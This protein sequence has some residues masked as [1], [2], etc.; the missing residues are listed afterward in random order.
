MDKEDYPS[1]LASIAASYA[2]RELDRTVY[3][4][5]LASDVGKKLSGLSD[6]QKYALEFAAYAASAIAVQRSSESGLVAKF[7][8]EVAADAPSEIARRMINGKSQFGTQD[9]SGVIENLSESDL[10]ALAQVIS[11]PNVGARPHYDESEAQPAED[12][13]TALGRL[14]DRISASRDRIRERRKSR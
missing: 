5:V 3:D 8:S 12:E 4:R 6:G 2:R 9:L 11:S 7:L 14:A 1:L 13:E 10:D